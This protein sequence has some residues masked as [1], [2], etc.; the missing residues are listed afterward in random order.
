MLA[1]PKN[2]DVPDRYLALIMAFP[3]KPIRSDEALDRA[4]QVVDRLIDRDDLDADEHDYLDVL[5][6]LIKKYESTHHPLPEVSEADMLRHLI[7][8]REI[9]QGRLAADTGIAE[10]TISAILAG[11]R[12][13]NRTHITALARYFK[14]SPAV[15]IPN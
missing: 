10:S 11:K 15:F 3:L 14:V 4:I 13:M 8:A 9:T 5:A 2:K 6:D 1:T 12:G 7:E